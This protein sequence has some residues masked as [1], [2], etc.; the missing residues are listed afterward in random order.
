MDFITV[1]RKVLKKNDELAAENRARF[2]G[3]GTFVLNLLSSPGAGKTTLLEQTIRLLGG[4]PR[5]AVVEGDVQTNHDARRIAGTGAPVV[6]IVTNGACHLEARLVQ[7]A[8]ANLD[9]N[10]VELLFIENVGNLVCPASFDLGEHKKVVIASTTEGADK[11]AKYP[12]AFRVS[13]VCVLNKVDLLPHVDFDVDEFMD[14]A[15]TVNPA[16]T[17]F[18]TSA[19]TGEGLDEWVDWLRVNTSRGRG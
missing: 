11:P 10:G 12:N 4:T 7:D 16:L 3:S 19:R 18:R 17:F 2:N 15:R 8:L 9:L 1:E 14:Y 13:D 6:Q 5:V